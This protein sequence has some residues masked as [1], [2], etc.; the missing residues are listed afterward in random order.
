MADNWV[1]T[2]Q[3]PRSDLQDGHI[4]QGHVIKFALKGSGSRGELFVPE[5][6]YDAQKIHDLID[7]KATAMMAVEAL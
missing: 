7:A 6:Q 5:A 1:V 2:S 3:Q 4:I